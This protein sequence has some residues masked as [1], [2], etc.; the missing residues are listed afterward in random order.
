MSVT[1]LEESART[2][3]NVCSRKV[4]DIVDVEM[5]LNNMAS[6]VKVRC[7]KGFFLARHPEDG[8]GGAPHPPPS[9]KTATPVNLYISTRCLMFVYM[10]L[11]Q[12]SHRVRRAC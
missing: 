10:L 2:I 8:G 4:T 9:G 11:G 6:N 1:A 12:Y 3:P 5:V 7:K